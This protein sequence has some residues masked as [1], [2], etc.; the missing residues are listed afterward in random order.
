MPDIDVDF[1]KDRRRSNLL[2]VGQ[3]RQGLCCP[4]NN[5]RDYG[6]EGSDK[7]CW[8]LDIPYAEVDK[9]AK[10]VPNT[11]NIT[12]DNSLR[13][14]PQLQELYDSNPREKN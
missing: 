13:T 7:R 2:C 4:D 14:E 6:C 8:T 9:I 10:L 3:I 12:I 1:C 11:L 5:I